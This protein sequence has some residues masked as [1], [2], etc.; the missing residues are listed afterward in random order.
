MNNVIPFPGTG[1]TFH[2][3]PRPL[4]EMEALEAGRLD[5]FLRSHFAERVEIERVRAQEF[6]AWVI[7]SNGYVEK[8]CS[9]SN[10]AS[11]RA[12]VSG[13][14]TGTPIVDRVRGA[15]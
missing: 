12:A 5:D 9:G 6:E 14:F 15:R 4:P 10:I 8:Y 13:L 7:Y 2:W 11:V 3:E 1:I